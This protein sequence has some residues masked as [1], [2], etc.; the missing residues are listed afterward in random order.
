M[1]KSIIQT[2]FSKPG[3]S[4][5]ASVVLLILRLIAGIA[6]ILHGWQKIQH[7]TAWVPPGG[8]ISISAFFQFL[9]AVSEFCGGIAWMLGFLT[10][11]ASFGIA[12]TMAVAVYLNIELFKAPF[13][14]QTGGPAYEL[15]L[16][17]LGIALLL[18]ILGPGKF[19]LDSQLF[20][21]RK[22]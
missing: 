13:V 11:L 9:A 10:P 2:A 18:F 1:I 4:T 20:G 22:Q 6:F 14:N 16:V 19:S 3:Q 12:C 7:P 17:Y 15:P 5:A 8:P 21:K